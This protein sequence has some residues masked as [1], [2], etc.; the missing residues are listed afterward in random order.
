MKDLKDV[1]GLDALNLNGSYELFTQNP[2]L[3][4]IEITACFKGHWMSKPLFK[5]LALSPKKIILF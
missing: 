3:K 1:C 5:P 2:G 4:C